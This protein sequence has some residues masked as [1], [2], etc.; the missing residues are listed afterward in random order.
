MALRYSHTQRGTTL[1]LIV[2]GG[3]LLAFGVVLFTLSTTKQSTPPFV[4]AVVGFAMVI[5]IVSAWIFS[6]LHVEVDDQAVRWHFGQGVPRFSL[7]LH[8]IQSGRVV[9]NPWY[10]GLGIHYTPNGWL[11]NV[12]GDSAV[13][14][15]RLEGRRVR[16]GSDEPEALAAAIA[17]ARGAT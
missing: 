12:S 7:P 6:T 8:G 17:S 1:V 5:S 10:Y 14:I 2:S 15:V 11:Y 16:I 13:E 4:W 9:N 3:M